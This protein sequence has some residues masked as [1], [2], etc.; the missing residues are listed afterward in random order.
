MSRGKLLRLALAVAVAAAFGVASTTFYSASPAD[1]AAV[2]GKPR[3]KSIP[4][5][6]RQHHRLAE[7]QAQINALFASVTTLNERISAT[8]ESIQALREQAASLQEQID[9]NAGDIDQLETQL[10]D[11]N[12]VIAQLQQNLDQ[13]A[14]TLALKQNI[15]HGTCPNGKHAAQVNADGSIVCTP[16]SGVDGLHQLTVWASIGIPPFGAVTAVA[17][18]PAGTV[19]TGGGYFPSPT[20]GVSVSYASGNSWV[21][22]AAS[23]I[24]GGDVSVQ[25]V[26]VGTT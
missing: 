7:L 19:L 26:C 23:N 3:P 17:S 13:Q 2:V 21:V 18:C 10:A 25:A 4:K 15:I 12:T 5:P 6:K 24:F 9:S 16:D 22:G 20:V 8:E 1:A 14:Q 11:T